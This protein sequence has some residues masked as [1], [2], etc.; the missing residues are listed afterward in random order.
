MSTAIPDDVRQFIFEH[1]DSVAQLEVL[2]FLRDRRSDSFTAEQISKELRANPS[3]VA[4]RLTHMQALGLLS[5]DQSNS[6]N[7]KYDPRS[8]E[9]SG[10][11][12]KLYDCYKIRQ[13]KVLELIF[14]TVKRARQFADAFTL[15]KPP[16]SEEDEN[17]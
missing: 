11:I 15:A 7:F 1:V 6:G 8:E 16:K 4:H 3:S 2:F 10:L 17:G 5:E 12:D 9:L 14:S 13:H